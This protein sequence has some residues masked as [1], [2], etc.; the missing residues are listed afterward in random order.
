MTTRP[1]FLAIFSFA[2]VLAA[3]AV[4]QDIKPGLYQ[5][6]SKMSGD[7]KVTEMMT[8]QK[9]ALAKM[10]PQQRQ[11]MADMPRQMA[12]MMEGMSPEQRAKMKEMMGDKA[13]LLESMQSMQMTFNADGSS[14]MKM[15]V[16][17]QMIDQRDLTGQHGDC[18]HNNGKMTGGVMKIAYTC[19]TPPSKGEGELRMTGPNSFITNMK[20]VSTD[21]ANKQ[22]MELASTSTWLGSSCGSVKPIDPKTFK[23]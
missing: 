21:P 6:T 10:T 18:K 7:N 14:S 16:T 4:A 11:Q 15:C 5:V 22:T 8:Q 19:T 17:K 1:P 2:A 23:K 3:P 9:D 13:E 12:K 20:M